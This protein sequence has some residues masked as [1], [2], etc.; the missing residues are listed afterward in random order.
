MSKLAIVSVDRPYFSH[1]KSRLKTT[2]E[3]SDEEFGFTSKIY[4]LFFH[5]DYEWPCLSFDVIRDPLGWDRKTFPHTAYFV[6]GTQSDQTDGAVDQILVTKISNMQNT[7]DD[8]DRD[9][10]TLQD[11][12]LQCR[13]SQHPGPV[14][15][16][17]SMPQQPEIIATWT[18]TGAVMIWDVSSAINSTNTEAAQ[19]ADQPVQSIFDCNV[20]GEDDEDEGYGLA[21]SKI[22][23]GILAIGQNSGVVS[24]W[25]NRQAA[26]AELH[27]FQAHTASVEDIVFSPT[28]DGFFATC[29]CDS[30]IA[31]WDSRALQAPVMKWTASAAKADINVIDWNARQS[32]LIVSGDDQGLINVWDIRACRGSPEPSP[33]GQINYHEDAICSVE[34]NPY[35]ESEF[36]VACEDGRVTVWDL[37]AEPE[38]L[39]QRME[40]I[41]D[42]LMF[43]HF[44]DEPKELHYHPQI[45]SMI[46]ITGASFEV[47]I[48][49]IQTDEDGPLPE[50][51]DAEE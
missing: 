20:D 1:N 19:T 4:R 18:E 8:D 37:S 49:D 38:E 22:T 47:I 32:N 29:S 11:A 35:D 10:E 2:M 41:P 34:W 40:D 26:F 25:E 46:A 24:L 31:V 17:R 13:A 28:D 48:P 36:A 51:D 27:K 14:T 39:D 45:R 12:K 42:Q 30:T 33:V 6:A 50:G 7:K 9:E 16:I 23:P 3:D 43:E 5:M 21:W 15:R 44:M